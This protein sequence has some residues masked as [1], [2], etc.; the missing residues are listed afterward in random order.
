MSS[1]CGASGQVHCSLMADH[2]VTCCF[3]SSPSVI[4]RL[5]NHRLNCY[6]APDTLNLENFFFQLSRAARC[7]CLLSSFTWPRCAPLTL[8]E[9]LLSKCKQFETSVKQMNPSDDPS[10]HCFYDQNIQRIRSSL[11]GRR[12]GGGIVEQVHRSNWQK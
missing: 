3:R 10:R 1:H 6:N 12:A 8:D 7:V 2:Q 9:I 11:N 4:R 5:L